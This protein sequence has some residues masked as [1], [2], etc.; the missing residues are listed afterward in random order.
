MNGNILLDMI[1]SIDTHL[2]SIDDGKLP[3]ENFF[4]QAKKIYE[5]KNSKSMKGGLKNLYPTGNFAD[6]VNIC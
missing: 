4:N 6:I 5:A 2:L 1:K 3:Y